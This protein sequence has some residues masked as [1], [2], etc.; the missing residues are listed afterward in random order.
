[1][2]IFGT[3]PY[4]NLYIRGYLYAISITKCNRSKE[5]IIVNFLTQIF[6]SCF[7][8]YVGSLISLNDTWFNNQTKIYL[9]NNW[10]SKLA[11]KVYHRVLC[12]LNQ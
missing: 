8:N 11:T 2:K 7:L 6:F 4:I 3:G 9:I 12:V 5:F 10:F 1:M